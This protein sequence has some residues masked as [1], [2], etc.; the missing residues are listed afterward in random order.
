MIGMH[1]YRVGQLQRRALPM[2]GQPDMTADEED[3]LEGMW[4]YVIDSKIRGLKNV[5]VDDNP[6]NRHYCVK[7]ESVSQSFIEITAK[8]II[9]DGIQI[10]SKNEAIASCIKDFN[11]S[12]NVNEDTIEDFFTECWRD[13][14]IHG[15]SLWR[16]ARYEWLDR[17]IDLQRVDQ[18]TIKR[19]VDRRFGW[20]K[21]VQQTSIAWQHS[22]K[23]REEYYK[24][25]NDPYN[26]FAD[27]VTAAY[28]LGNRI[29]IPFEPQ[30]VIWIKNFTQP[31]VT[32]AMPL[33]L[34]KIWILFFMRKYSEKHW[35]PPVIAYI[36]D[37]KNNY[38]PYSPQELQNEI[39][40]MANDITRL[41]N[42]AGMAT[43]GYNRVE[44][45]KTDTAKSSE[46]YVK[47]LQHLNE[48]IMYSL[49]G[50]MGQ[51][52]AV[53]NFKAISENVDEGWLRFVR[54][55]RRKFEFALRR[56]YTRSLLPQ[57]GIFNSKAEDIE[58]KWSRLQTT[59]V[60]T[61]MSAIQK[62]VESG[63]FVS[64]QEVRNAAAEGFPLLDETPATE[65]GWLPDN[66]K[67]TA[68][69]QPN[70]GN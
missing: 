41:R 36:G 60:D 45:L 18:R 59:P 2:I 29:V 10:T 70:S 63:V 31:P 17:K 40:Q 58:I 15:N 6:L 7:W 49:F 54:G 16:I 62:A 30:T 64:Q 68:V 56:F 12:I 57:N 52:S 43:A 53:G 21:W 46:I 32:A 5:V 33:L 27:N 24:D 67:P 66:L 50:S 20:V 51:R 47:Y 39:N 25:P 37:P 8:T 69:G 19:Y 48:E 13:A 44:P 38:F 61:L 3:S 34:Y 42:F 28:D 14:V 55:V 11:N 1:I 26:I 4:D 65:K 23:S 9:G 35:A 22:H